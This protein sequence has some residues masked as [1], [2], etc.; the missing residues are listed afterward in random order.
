[1]VKE[2]FNVQTPHA[3]MLGDNMVQ[4]KE[5][6]II[7]ITTRE[8]GVSQYPYQSL[9]MG[10]HIQD[11]PNSIL[12]NRRRL[13]EQ[14]NI[15]LNQWVQTEQVHGTEIFRVTKEHAGQGARDLQSVIKNG[16]GL[17]TTDKGL[18]LVACFADCV[19][20]YFYSKSGHAIGLLHAGW[21][22]TVHLASQKM[23]HLWEDELNVKP[24][25]IQVVIGP[26][27]GPCCY[28]VDEKVVS[29]IHKI[30]GIHIEQVA[31]PI[32][33]HHVSL[34]LKK[35]NCLL[36]QQVGVPDTNIIQ[37]SYCTSCS[38][39]LFFSHRKEKGKTGRILGFIGINE[40]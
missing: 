29:E 40:E 23:V 9:N 39:D 12:E 31:T 14:L 33:Q 19:P 2:P 11:N 30:K 36:L 38:N 8:H 5:N 37:S 6:I 22:G 1:M 7:G 15:P 32:D 16:D 28:E 25:D 4:G 21:K 13:S 24:N 35:L 34:D 27:I 3:L 17:Y 18:L 26:S 20:L 10:F